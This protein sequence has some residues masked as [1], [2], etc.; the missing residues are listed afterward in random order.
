M[1]HLGW[2][3]S[4]HWAGHCCCVPCRLFFTM[5]DMKTATRT[6]LGC[7]GADPRAWHKAMV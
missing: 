7:T 2:E 4:G 3:R 6:I 5:Q 1:V